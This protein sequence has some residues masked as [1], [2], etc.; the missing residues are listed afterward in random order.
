MN[1]SACDWK[2]ALQSHLSGSNETGL[3]GLKLRAGL[4]PPAQSSLLRARGV[5]N[6]A[7]QTK[8]CRIFASNPFAA[9]CFVLR[10]SRRCRDKLFTVNAATWC[11]GGMDDCWPVLLQNRL[12]L[13]SR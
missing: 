13:R 5:H 9:R 3:P 10:Q 7:L 8:R 1:A 12:V 11:R 4:L 2:Q 6:L